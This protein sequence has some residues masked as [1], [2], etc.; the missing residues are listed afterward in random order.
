MSKQIL[1]PGK[2][3]VITCNECNCKFTFEKIDLD[4]NNQTSCPCCGTLCTASVKTAKVE[5]EETVVET[6]SIKKK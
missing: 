2:Y 6:T 1:E 5:T 3:S 4:A